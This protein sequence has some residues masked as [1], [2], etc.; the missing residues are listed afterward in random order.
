VLAQPSS[1]HTWVPGYWTWRAN[2][3]QWVAGHWEVPP[4]ASAKWVAPRWQAESGAVR[5]YEGYWN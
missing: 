1:A 3:Y 5:F 4:Y 2:Q